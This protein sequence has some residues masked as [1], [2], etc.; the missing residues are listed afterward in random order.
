MPRLIMASASSSNVTHPAPLRYAPG[1]RLEIRDEEWMVRQVQPSATG[2]QALTVVGVSELV[3]GQEAI[4]LDRLEHVTV[5]DPRDTKLESD[6]S[7]GY[8][9]T[10]LY[11]ESLLRQSPVTDEGITIGHRGAIARSQ[12]QLTPAG[13]ALS[14]PRARILIADGVGL[15][16]TVEVGILLSELIRRGRGRRILVVALRSVLEQFQMELWSRFTIPLV[17]LDSAGIE[18]VQRRI[19]ANMNPFHFYDRVIIS[20]DTLKRDEKYRRFLT[21]CQWDAIVIDECQHVAERSVTRGSISQR[22]RLAKLLAS[23]CDSLILTSATPHDGRPESFASLMNLLDPTAVPN[24]EALSREAVERLVVRRF[25]KDIEHEVGEQFG[26]RKLIPH[27]IVANPAEEALLDA[28]AEA[29]FRT[30]GRVRQDGANA[31]RGALFQTLLR[32]AALSSSHAVATTITQRLKHKRLQQTD[33]DA[34]AD[35]TTLRELESLA[36]AAKSSPKQPASKLAALVELLRNFGV[37]QHAADNRVVVFS[38]RIDT[39]AMLEEQLPKLLDLPEGSVGRFE[40]STDDS[41]QQELV[42][43]FGNRESKLRVLLCSDAAAEGIN[44]HF[45]CHRLVHY[46]IPWSFITLEQRNGRIDRFG[47]TRD[48]EI[49]VLLTVSANER[50]RGDM[51]V[52]ERLVEKE[53]EAHKALGDVQALLDLHDAAAEEQ[54]LIDGIEQGRAAED[55]IP[56]PT[57]AGGD[58]LDLLLGDQ[59][60]DAREQQLVDTHERPS[61]YADDLEFCLDGWRE[62][63][64]S[65][66]DVERPIEHPQAQGLEI[67]APED[68]RQRFDQLPPE[69]VR[70]SASRFRLTRDRELLMREFQRARE[71]EQGWP[72]WHLLW[73]QHPIHEWLTDRLVA[74]M[75]RHAAPVI[76]VARGLDAGQRCF[77]FQGVTSNQRSQPIL[78]AWFGLVFDPA[79]KH[80][81]TLDWD[82][83]VERTGL[84]KPVPND[85]A[86]IDTQPLEPLRTPAVAAATAYMKQLRDQRA[87][88]LGPKLKQEKRRLKSWEDARLDAIEAKLASEP[89]ATQKAQLEQQRLDVEA[90]V[91]RRVRWFEE[92]M[93]TEDQPYLRLAA[94]LFQT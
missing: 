53:T 23:T 61:L 16:K 91:A 86:S 48:P 24:V 80:I 66:P 19:P 18:R 39:L 31:G 63:A 44:L 27:R 14:Q 92:T 1:A 3:R 17:R 75:T 26:D 37:H 9:K 77:V 74:H 49:H 51:R 64:D 59:Q 67:V 47:Q 2:G 85:G 81:E 45:Y 62:L 83:L 42:R 34:K 68:L 94:V 55:I 40:G 32:K 71:R 65:Y 50:I 82:P 72:S 46:D 21:A 38:E 13:L 60:L 33:A 57:E 25:K 84:D 7:P 79:G 8:R 52:L 73:E 5:L 90:Q 54:H 56:E 15:G 70:E 20:I 76:R 11:L 36:S 41:R 6:R 10:R 29:S 30:I 58:F 28:L 88:Q 87:K 89:R 12:Y 93:T 69:L 35:A 22:A 4:F 43:E 78:C